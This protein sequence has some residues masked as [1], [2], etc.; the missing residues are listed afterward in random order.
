MEFDRKVLRKSR[1]FWNFFRKNFFRKFEDSENLD[2]GNSPILSQNPKISNFLSFFNKFLTFFNISISF[3]THQI[4][5]PPPAN[6]H[7]RKDFPDNISQTTTGFAFTSTC[8][9]FLPPLF[10]LL[11]SYL[12][13]LPFSLYFLPTNF[14]SSNF[15][16]YFPAIFSPFPSFLPFSASFSSLLFCVFTVS[17]SPFGLNSAIPPAIPLK[18]ERR[19]TLRVH[20]QS[21]D[22]K[23]R[24]FLGL[25]LRSLYIYKYFSC[26]HFLCSFF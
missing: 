24:R 14:F 5:T 4:V 7:G 2:Q 15:S 10:P 9:A 26:L 8:P 13:S 19:G 17:L 22:R 12:P 3:F 1:K 21:I 20:A 23:S 16:L 6:D 18:G 25:Q 11:L